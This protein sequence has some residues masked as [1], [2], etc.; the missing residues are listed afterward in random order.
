MHPTPS[1]PRFPPPSGE[2]LA[3]LF[4]NGSLKHPSQES[5]TDALLDVADAVMASAG[6]EVERVRLTGLE[7]PP[8]IVADATVRGWGHDDW[9]SL[10]EKVRSAD[11]LVVGSPIWLGSPSSVTTRFLE[12]L[13]AMSGQLNDR[14]QYV[15]YG[16]AGGCIVTGNEDGVKAVSKQVLYALQH[17]GY[18]IPPQADAGWIGEVGPGKS[19]ADEGSGG[20]SNDFTQRNTT[21]MAWNL[22]HAANMLRRVEGYPAWGNVPEAWERGERFGHPGV[23]E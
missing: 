7:L 5:H 13:Y 12:R 20:P 10:W 16:K 3:A 1:D 21:F 14:G 4:V 22:I 8:G 6:V 11:I 9:P 18:T 19:Y 2:G 17:V 23:P 15:F